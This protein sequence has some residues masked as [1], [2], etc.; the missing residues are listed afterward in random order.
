[1]A[2]TPDAVDRIAADAAAGTY[3]SMHLNFCGGIPPPLLARLAAAT[4]AGPPAAIS[5]IA[6]VA[7][8]H[9]AFASLDAGL[10]SLRRPAAFRALHAPGAADAAIRAE[11]DAIVEG[12]HGVVAT[13]GAVPLI[14]AAKGGPAEA[15]AA[16]LDARLRE[17]ARAQRGPGGAP[18][19][20][21]GGPRP[22]LALFDRSADLATPLAHAWTY[23]P[24]V[25]DALGLDLNRVTLPGDGPG[26]KPVTVEVG[27][28]DWFWAGA[29][30]QP[31]PAVAE[32]V[33]AHLKQYRAAVDAVN[34]SAAAGGGGGAGAGAAAP[35]GLAAAVASLPA[36]ADRKKVLDRHTNLATRLLARIKARGL[37]AYAAVEEDV[38]AGKAGGGGV[39]AAVAGLLS[40]ARGDA[41]DRTRAVL[42]AALASPAP[43]TDDECA[44]LAAAAGPG[45]A[46]ELAP[47]LAYVRRL[48][49]LAASAA[50]PSA[51]APPSSAAS[52]QQL[53]SWADRALGAGAATIARAARGLLAGERAPPLVLALDALT[54][55]KPS[56]DLDAFATYDP[57]APTPGPH[58]AAGA[59]ATLVGGPGGDVL[60]CVVGGGCL[61]EAEACASWA[62]RGAPAR[63]L[64]YGATELV[65]GAA[66]AGDLAALGRAAGLA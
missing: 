24:L 9:L 64:V 31:F 53:L 19:P 39:A 55:G 4:A 11:I 47:A 41:A 5:R 25:A 21:A 20:R 35:P 22:L 16:G 1:M 45:A 57:R 37:D 13:L 42:V 59:A 40:D 66:F 3:D 8:Q 33:D 61:A 18:A 52:G 17:A 65:G 27:P 23:R 14:R 50:P 62:A 12:L 54:S 60:V 38:L 30:A 26:A 7:D 28:G 36:L 15:V 44:T 48:R 2:A 58:P 49:R 6:S 46:G 29:A 56:P 43:L 51:A 10:F 63:R 32:S 34:R